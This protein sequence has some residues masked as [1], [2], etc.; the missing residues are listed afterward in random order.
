ML[1]AEDVSL[2]EAGFA[3]ATANCLEAVL[4]AVFL[5]GGLSAV[6]KLFGR[7]VFQEEVGGCVLE[8]AD[9]K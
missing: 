9:L 2:T 6:D 5:D 8:R 1:L 4:G 3:H 7:L